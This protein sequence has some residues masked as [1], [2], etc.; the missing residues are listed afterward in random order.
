MRNLLVGLIILSLIAACAPGQTPAP[1]TAT[2]LANLDLGTG[3]SGF[4][5]NI[6]AQEV[7]T[8]KTFRGFYAAGSHGAIVLPTSAPVAIQV[9]APGTYVVYAINNEAPED[10]H[11][12]ATGCPPATDCASSELLAI[13]VKPGGSY[14]VTITDRSAVLPT[15][16][17]PVAVPWKP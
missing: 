2:I 5:A 13:E 15:P 7:T 12:G 3:G 6:Y 14:P 11:Y 17:A 9:E 4:A 10:Y 16:D 1:Q 8:G